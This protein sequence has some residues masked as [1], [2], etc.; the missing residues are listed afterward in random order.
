MN[1][2]VNG[3]PLTV[4]VIALVEWVKRFGVEGKTIN[5]VSLIIGTIVGVAY[6]YAQSSLFTFSDWFSALVYGLTLGLTASG[7]YDATQSAVRG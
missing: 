7:L 6:W 2:I 5:A 1:P 4:L 3:V